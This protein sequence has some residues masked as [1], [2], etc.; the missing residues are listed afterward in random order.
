MVE[1]IVIPQSGEMLAAGKA[2]DKEMHHQ[3]DKRP[4]PTQVALCKDREL[5]GAMGHWAFEKWL[6]SLAIPYVT[7]PVN[8]RKGDQFDTFITGFGK[9][10]LKTSKQEGNWLLSHNPTWVLYPAHQRHRQFKVVSFEGWMIPR[11]VWIFGWMWRQEFFESASFHRE[12]EILLKGGVEPMRVI[13][14]CFRVDISRLHP[15]LDLFHHIER[16]KG[17]ADGIPVSV[18][19][20]PQADAHEAQAL[21]QA[22]A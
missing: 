16:A 11:Y 22:E 2:M 8:Y 6:D 4:P 15:P 5:I 13:H 12:G 17:E 3:Y 14:D 7:A 18:D 10:E 20:G 1:W 19:Q 21:R 9:V